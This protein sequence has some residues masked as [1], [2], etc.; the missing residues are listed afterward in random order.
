VSAGVRYIGRSY[1]NALNTFEVPSVTLLDFGARLDLG[2]IN[3]DWRNFELAFKLNNVTDRVYAFCSE[4][5]EY[6]ARR[7]GL[8]QLTT[9]W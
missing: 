6:G 1:G 4:L 9:R 5:C 2:R 3:A 8:V 7:T